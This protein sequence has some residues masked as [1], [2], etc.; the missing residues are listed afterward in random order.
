MSLFASLFYALDRTSK[1][2]EKCLLLKEYFGVAP[3]KE[4]TW[5]L[6]FLLGG[7]ITRLFTTTEMRKIISRR[8]N[9]PLWLVEDSYD[10]VGD[11]AETLALLTL[12]IKNQTSSSRVL[13]ELAE[14]LQDLLTISDINQ[15]EERLWKLI[16]STPD[17][18]RL[19]LFKLMIGGLRIGVSKGLVTQVLAELYEFDIAEMAHRLV[20]EW[21]PTEE[22]YQT[23]M[24]RTSC[25]ESLGNPYPFLLASPLDSTQESVIS[26]SLPEWIIEWKWDG[27]RAQLLK[28][29]GH[30]IIWSR[31]EEVITE[32]FPE[33]ISTMERVEH[34]NIVLDGEIIV[35]RDGQ[36]QSFAELQKR[37]NR[38]KISSQLLKTLPVRFIAYDLLEL[39]GKD[40]RGEPLSIRRQHLE[41]F[42]KEH[43]ERFLL[44]SPLHKV[45]RP[46]QMSELR[47]K[48]RSRQSEGLMIKH[49]ASSYGTGRRGSQ[50][51]K[52][53]VDPLRLD[54]VLLYAQKGH[55]RRADLYTSYT[56]GVWKN[57][58]L[59]T[60]TKAYSGLTNSEIREVD[61][62]IR[63][64]QLQKFGP[65]QA[66]T[67]SLVFEIAFDSI[68][69]SKR[70]KAGVALRFPRIVRIRKDKA[71][72]EADTIESVRRL[73]E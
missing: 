60:I 54:V 51:W 41:T 7:K 46:S 34:D 57:G 49:R 42:F 36:P 70:H 24:K 33:L 10:T 1:T 62:F 25:N 31:G 18:E 52:W 4:A 66:V 56:F 35:W 72:H 9:L 53:K 68:Q 48:A 47:A 12:P 39:A 5:A 6:Y 45:T 32:T 21:Q 15:R 30:V 71:A 55:G 29:S 38:K 23:L 61:A 67:P 20:G 11:L 26:S 50:W 27:I 19:I 13:H 69:L 16:E 59:V 17:K 22:R 73:L 63:K 2:S 28:R 3:V 44:L 14:S 64:N 65:V 37:L 43:E 58:E 8:M 40:L